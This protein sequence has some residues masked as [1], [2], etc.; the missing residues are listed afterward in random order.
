MKPEIERVLEV[1][2]ISLMGDVA[3]NASPGYRQA[4]VLATAVALS[5]VREEIDRIAQRRVLENQALRRLFRDA[6]PAV[7]EA[8]LRERLAAAADESETDL[9]VSSLEAANARLRGL[10]I[11]LHVHVE[12]QATEE[13]RRVESAIWRELQASTERRKLALDSF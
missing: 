13:A 1:C 6:L 3:P 7:S 5:C 10:L 8:A 9:L 11:E 2:A 12:Q 4:S